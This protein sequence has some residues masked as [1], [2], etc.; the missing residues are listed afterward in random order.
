MVGVLDRGHA[1]GVRVVDEPLLLIRAVLRRRLGCSHVV[2]VG[3]HRDLSSCRGSVDG[4]N[5]LQWFGRGGPTRSND[6]VRVVFQG[7]RAGPPLFSGAWRAPD[8]WP[9]HSYSGA[10]KHPLEGP[11][12]H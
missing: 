10:L 1:V 2:G 5:V 9:N 12:T 11:G 6:S 4:W 7:T 3:C 8:E